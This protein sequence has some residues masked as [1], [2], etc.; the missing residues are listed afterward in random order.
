[1]AGTDETYEVPVAATIDNPSSAIAEIDRRGFPRFFRQIWDETL[2]ALSLF[3]KP[4]RYFGTCHDLIERVSGLSKLCPL[5]EQNGEAIIGC[6]SNDVF[7]RFYYEDAGQENPNASIEV[8]G[9]NYQ[10][11][12]TT[13]LVELI[14]SGRWDD[15]DEMTTFLKYQRASELRTIL[16]GYTDEAGEANLSRFR[17][18]LIS[19][20]LRESL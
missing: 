19:D 5:W 1:M 12:A 16:E 14:E 17:E 9:K 2:P 11:F 3:Q 10:Q 18:S 4:W 13:I 15:F 20:T 7:I 6:L 8:L